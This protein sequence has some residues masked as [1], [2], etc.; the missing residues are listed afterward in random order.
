MPRL[1]FLLVLAAVSGCGTG[2]TYTIET[3]DLRNANERAARFCQQQDATARLE[4]VQQR[5]D[6]AIQTYRCV[7]SS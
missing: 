4:G 5:A 1:P 7:A 6:R 3:A 2:S